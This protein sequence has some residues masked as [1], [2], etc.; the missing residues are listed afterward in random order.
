MVNL[1][2]KQDSDW[3]I[4]DSE[5]CKVI[6]FTSLASIENGKIIISN[7]T[8]P[9]ASVV[10]ECKKLPEQTK[11]FIC[12]KMDF[13]N[14]WTAFKE[15]GVR[16]NEEVIIFYSR[17]HLKIYAKLFLAF[18]PRLW[19]MICQKGAFEL[20]T[21]PKSRPELQGEARFLAEKPIIDWKPKVM[22]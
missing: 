16:E 4:I 21:D 22:K 12:H 10:L 19:V 5:P 18:M 14:L 17:K 1:T 13:Q 2:L 20:I 15:R 6:N 8:E 7:K 9:Y 11:G 3:S